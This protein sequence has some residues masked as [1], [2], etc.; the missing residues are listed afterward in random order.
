[1]HMFGFDSFGGGPIRVHDYATFRRRAHL[2]L[3]I[4]GISRDRDSLAM[5]SDVSHV[6]AVL[7]LFMVVQ[8][9]ESALPAIFLAPATGGG[10]LACGGG[11]TPAPD[12]AKEETFARERER[13][14]GV[15]RLYHSPGE[16]KR[17]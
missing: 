2:E 7:V 6:I 12:L 5:E 9:L 8:A 13:E 3:E 1:M 11:R 17:D 4:R 16:G 10:A 15:K 14:I